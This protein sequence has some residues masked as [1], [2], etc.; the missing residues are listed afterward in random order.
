[1]KTNLKSVG[2]ALFIKNST[3]VNEETYWNKAQFLTFK[4]SIEVINES[5]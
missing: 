4:I 1:M 5:E 2:W 3:I